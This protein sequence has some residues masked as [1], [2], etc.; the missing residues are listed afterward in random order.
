MLEMML[1]SPW[2]RLVDVVVVSHG[3]RIR[4]EGS[5]FEAAALAAVV[6]VMGPPAQEQKM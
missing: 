5:L 2:I 1:R 3:R 6:V 4:V